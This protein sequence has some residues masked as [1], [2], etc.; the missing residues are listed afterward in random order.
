LKIRV[1]DIPTRLFHWFLV[2][3]FVSAL[4]TSWSDTQLD[5]HIAVG[6]IALGLIVF[7]IAWGFGGSKYSRFSQ[8]IKSS[9]EVRSFISK[10]IRREPIRYIGHNPVVGWFVIVL[11]ALITL[12]ALTGIIITGGE[13]GRGVWAKYISYEIASYARPTHTFTAYFA[14]LMVIGHIF[15]ALFHD[16]VLRERI[17]VSMITGNKEDDG[18]GSTESQ[19]TA[20]KEETPLARRFAAVLVLIM[21]LLAVIYIPRGFSRPYSAPRV[22][23][24]E[25]NWGALIV[26]ELWKDE[27]ATSCHGAFYPTLLPAESWKRIISGLEDHFDDDASLDEMETA[28]IEKF[29]LNASAERSDSEASKKIL[30]SMHIGSV[31]IRITETPYWKKKH[32]YIKEDVYRREAVVSRSNCIACHPGSD[33]GSFEDNDISI[34]Q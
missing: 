30:A 4:F 2:C 18:E 6:Y 27:C 11:L 23:D 13:E 15:A 19:A 17:I 33:N 14:A 5:Y 22:L 8:F 16:I 9:Q 34:P 31:P 28:E 3:A 29:L 20:V 32:G 1:W 12:T 10:A 7:R 26:N 24:A 25:G 21:A